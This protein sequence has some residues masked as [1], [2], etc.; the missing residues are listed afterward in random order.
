MRLSLKTASDDDVA[1]KW[2]INAHVTE[3]ALAHSSKKN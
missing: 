3:R 1:T 2:Q